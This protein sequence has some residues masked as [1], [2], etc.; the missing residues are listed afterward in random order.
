V[1]PCM[2]KRGSGVL[3][4]DHP[5]NF[6]SDGRTR[7]SHPILVVRSVLELSFFCAMA[8]PVVSYLP[9]AEE[10]S[11]RLAC[12]QGVSKTEALV[13]LEPHEIPVPPKSEEG[14]A[15]VVP[16]LV[17]GAPA[18][19]V[20]GKTAPAISLRVAFPSVQQASLCEPPTVSLL[21][22]GPLPVAVPP[23]MNVETTPDPFGSVYLRVNIRFANTAALAGDEVFVLCL[24]WRNTFPE[25]P[26]Y[27]SGFT[28]RPLIALPRLPLLSS[29]LSAYTNKNKEAAAAAKLAEPEEP[30][31]DEIVVVAEVKAT[32]KTEPVLP[33]KKRRYIFF[34][35]EDAKEVEAVAEAEA[36]EKEIEVVIEPVEPVV[37]VAKRTRL[38]GGA[39]EGPT[40]P[41]A[42]VQWLKA[43]RNWSFEAQNVVHGLR[44]SGSKGFYKNR[45]LTAALREECKLY[46]GE[47]LACKACPRPVYDG[48]APVSA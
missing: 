20:S 5:E 30:E 10:Y 4:Y 1:R 45:S 2:G 39:S 31:V 15:M 46:F 27:T 38:A 16:A 6:R 12:V 19:A 28:I 18:C 17:E 29:L 23:V 11:W 22:A 14:E 44:A 24:H 48:A 3:V 9:V 21:S 8:S 34:V 47:V 33:P 37:P 7:G 36:E 32:V 43:A 42:R 26:L 35:K 41:I 40:D 13:V 25:A